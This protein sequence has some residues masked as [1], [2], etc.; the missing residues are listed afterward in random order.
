MKKV[1]V[2]T[3]A[4]AL[5]VLLKE[6]GVD[7]LFGNAGTDA[8][9]LIEA[10]ARLQAAGLPAP[11]PVTVA[12]EMCA[13]SMAQGYARVARR[14]AAVFVHVSVGT[15]NAAA[16]IMNAARQGV[17]VLVMAGRTP[18]LED[19]ATGARDLRIH[20]AQESYDQAAMVREYVKWDYELRDAR[21]LGVVLDRALAAAMA[22]PQG[23]V[24]LA[25]P[26]ERLMETVGEFSFEE[27]NRLDGRGASQP[28][29][30]SLERAAELVA[31]A[32]SPLVV[33]NHMGR[34]PEAVAQ[35][36]AFAEE[37][38]VP[39]LEVF[40]ES[41][42]FPADHPLH[43]GFTPFPLVEQADLIIA[44][45][46]DVP[47]LPR[48]GSP[49]AGTPVIQVGHDPFFSRYPIRGFPLDVALVGSPALSLA[50]VRRALEKSR[51]GKEREIAAR[52]HRFTAAHHRYLDDRRRVAQAESA[53]RPISMNWLSRCLGAA[54][55]E[56]TLIVNEYDLRSDQLGLNREG[57]FLGSS[58]VSGL[59]WGFG[60]ALGAK[61]AA[62]D[63][64][65]VCALGDGAY[66]FNNPIACHMTAVAESIP[67]LVVIFNNQAWNAVRSAV[68]DVAPDGWAVR[69]NDYALTHLKPSPEFHR[70]AE[71]CGGY[72]E[73]VEDP[74]E[75]PAAIG[76]GLK[77]VR[78]GKHALLNVM[79]AL[80]P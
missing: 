53:A 16:G 63:R 64:T 77:Q 46:T 1:K 76:R 52:R 7:Y 43:L 58:A 48:R 8:A 29:P 56:R 24:Y 62:P 70:I 42:N 37:W 2:E 69:G 66:I 32:R 39:V 80:S 47:W 18:I 44:V 5:L 35:L 36:V 60:A 72:G 73:R 41:M 9:P 50:A 12:H 49:G 3:A 67:V 59:G 13:L 55:D 30:S 33:A 23:P 34:E 31:R 68:A 19:G 11:K 4:E 61:L 20:W 45:E 27:R 14:P 28:D 40:R 71:A 78:D 79:C 26:R 22:H 38:G 17:P 75:V 54:A 57:T 51:P 10:F 65:V 21:Q 15:A 6:R 74:A 25:L